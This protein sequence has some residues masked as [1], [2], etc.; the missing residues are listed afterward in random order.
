MSSPHWE[1]LVSAGADNFH[2]EER[3]LS[4]RALETLLLGT[5]IL[6]APPVKIL[7][8]LDAQLLYHKGVTCQ[9]KVTSFFGY[10]G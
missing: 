4:R 3:L 5:A 10:L 1:H 9:H 8:V 7:R 6:S 2:T